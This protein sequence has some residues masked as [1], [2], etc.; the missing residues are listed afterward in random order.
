MC[1]HRPERTL[2]SG[3]FAP[4]AWR[5]ALLALALAIP[6]SVLSRLGKCS[7]RWNLAAP[8]LAVGALLF[9]R[10]PDRTPPDSGVLAPADGRVSVVREEGDRVRV[11]VFM[12]VTDVHVNRA[13]VGGRVE[14]VD[15]EPGKH[16]PAFSKES[17]RNEKLHVRFPDHEV[18]L[19]AGAFARRIHPYVD[20]GDHLGR[21]ERL[22]HISFGS[23]AD[24]LLPESVDH[25]DLTVR[26]G[27][28]VRAGETRIAEL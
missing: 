2:L 24:V 16:R 26:R 6:V 23:R 7:R 28:K 27:Q 11:G 19:V 18:T 10:D 1:G 12:N 20:E 22:G 9:H 3:S 17:D 5:Y 8:A 14:A 4:G 13:P 21:G 25:A 15:H